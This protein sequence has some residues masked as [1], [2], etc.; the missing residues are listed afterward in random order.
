MNGDYLEIDGN[1]L[2]L[3]PTI[4]KEGE[5]VNRIAERVLLRIDSDVVI[6]TEQPIFHT[7]E[8]RFEFSSFPGII[9]Y[10]DW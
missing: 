2:I 7:Y 1:R 8:K 10:M 4:F 3:K 9:G 6:I 5:S